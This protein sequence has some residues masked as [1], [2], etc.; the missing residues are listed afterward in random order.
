MMIGNGVTNIDSG[1]FY[2]CNSLTS[3]II[4]NGV[5]SIGFY[6][7]YDCTSL[8]SVTFSGKNKATVQGMANYSWDIKSG[9]VIHCTDGDITI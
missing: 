2:S 4:G 1:A 5:T 6:T 9:C 3:V 7:F 8:T